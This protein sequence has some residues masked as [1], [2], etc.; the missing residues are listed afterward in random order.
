[1][2]Q[3][4]NSLDQTNSARI[5]VNV[6]L[7]ALS[8]TCAPEE[9]RGEIARHFGAFDV[10]IHEFIQGQDFRSVIERAMATGCD[11]VLACGGDGT[12]SLVASLLIGSEIQLAILPL[13]TANV[14]ARE[15]N[16]PIEL[17]GAC[18]LAASRLVERDHEAKTSRVITID[19]MKVGDRHYWTQVGVGIDA[20]MIQTTTSE[21]KRRLGKLAYVLSATK[22][23]FAF[24]PRRFTVTIDGVSRQLR[25]SEIV[26]ANTGI[27]GQPPFRWGPDIRADDGR[28]NVC[29]VNPSR[30]HDYVRLLWVAFRGHRVKTQSIE[31]QIFDRSLTI[32]SKHRLPVQADGEIVC[33]TPVTISVVSQALRIVV[34]QNDEVHY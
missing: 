5:R 34:P 7:N 24:K 13:G 1:M 16:I 31:H 9:V 11:Q 8:G 27:M 30:L 17:E 6:F 32:D 12:I 25:A 19:A 2:A 23:I 20:L 3:P 15:L 10:Q 29:F 18:R 33:E 28:L 26:V 22:H 21:A 4:L 14:L